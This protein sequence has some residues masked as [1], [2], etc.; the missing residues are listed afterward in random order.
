MRGLLGMLL[1]FLL[2]G[3]SVWLGCSAGSG[4]TMPSQPGDQDGMLQFDLPRQ[5]AEAQGEVGWS[6]AASPVEAQ[7]MVPL[8]WGAAP[9]GALSNDAC[10][11]DASGVAIGR[12][13]LRPGEGREAVLAWESQA[14]GTAEIS[15]TLQGRAS[16]GDGVSVSIWHN[17]SRLTGPQTVPNSP[18]SVTLM[19]MHRVTP[20]DVV[21]FRLAPRAQ[22]ADDWFVYGAKVEVTLE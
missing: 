3:V 13:W 12:T 11:R 16:G 20:G 9:E 8:I 6:Y 5:F 22:Y 19:S 18:Q 15:L 2:L 17:G 7:G 4:G 10:W 21:T 14:R 1:G